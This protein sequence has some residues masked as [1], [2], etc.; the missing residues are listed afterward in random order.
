MLRGRCFGRLRCLS[1]N[2]VRCGRQS[3][4]LCQ[5]SISFLQPTQPRLVPAQLIKALVQ[6][7]TILF[8]AFLVAYNKADRASSTSSASDSETGTMTES[9]A[10]LILGVEQQNPTIMQRV[11]RSSV[12]PLTDPQDRRVADEN[13]KR[14]FEIALKHNNMYLAGK[15]SNAYR[16]CVNPQWDEEV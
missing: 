5:R 1:N 8:Q 12:L 7:A 13:F 14:M 10:I 11:K 3:G 16:L 2:G 15:L 4:V 6:G 9:E